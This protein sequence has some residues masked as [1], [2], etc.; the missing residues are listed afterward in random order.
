MRLES[1]NVDLPVDRHRHRLRL[2]PILS[3]L[4][5]RRDRGRRHMRR[6]SRRSAEA[7]FSWCCLVGRGVAYR[8]GNV[9]AQKILGAVL[10]G[11]VLA[12]RRP[13]LVA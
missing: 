1:V 10:V 7:G 2:H 11:L 9:M 3:D 13:S 6:R 12:L 5:E 4:S 8:V